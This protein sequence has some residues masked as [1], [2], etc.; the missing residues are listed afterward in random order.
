M[1]PLI[2]AGGGTC[3]VTMGIMKT[4]R[5]TLG[6]VQT[7]T[8]TAGNNLAMDSVI[9]LGVGA[10]LLATITKGG[11]SGDV[12]KSSVLAKAG[13]TKSDPMSCI[14]I[15]CVYVFLQTRL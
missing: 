11:K 3:V 10:P 1:M 5:T 12:C 14:V 8:N 15:I 6:V 2:W 9:A 13:Q 7:T 4:V